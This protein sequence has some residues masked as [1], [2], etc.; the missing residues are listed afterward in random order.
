MENNTSGSLCITAHVE[1]LTRGEVMQSM[2]RIMR[3]PYLILWLAVYGI[4]AVVMA[5]KGVTVYTVFGPAVILL[6]IAGAY[7]YS[8]YKNF[9]KMGYD[10][11]EMDYQ[12]TPKGYKLT[13]GDNSAE[14][15]WNT[16]W[17][18]ETKSD[19]LLYSDKHNC[20]IL[21][22]RFLQEGEKEKLL[23]WARKK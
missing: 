1:G 13:V 22:K 17:I 9:P 18:V 15:T 3:K 14:F 2:R 23:L 16:A 19:L 5:F 20:S 10:K 21:P 7:E 11:A 12:L 8:G 4:M 6:L